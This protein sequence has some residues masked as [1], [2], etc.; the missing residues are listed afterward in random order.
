MKKYLLLPFFILLSLINLYGQ[1]NNS[2]G[3]YFTNKDKKFNDW[4]V[5][6]FGGYSILQNAD[7]TSW[8]G[9]GLQGL[10]P[11][12]DLNFLVN[13]QITHAFGLSA[14][15][16]YGNT[17]QKGTIDD[18][19]LSNYIGKAWG[20]TEYHAISIIGDVNLSN[21]LRRTDNRTNFVWELHAYAGAGF[22][23]YEAKRNN[24]NGSGNQF[25]T[26]T[27]QNIDDKSF[28]SQVGWG[29]RR[30]INKSVDVEFKNMYVLTGDETFDASGKPAPGHWTAAD[31]KASREDN[32][33]T[34]SLGVHY[35]FGKHDKALQWVD[36]LQNLSVTVVGNT[37]PLFECIDNDNDGVCDQW[38]KCLE[39]P[40]GVKV[41]G[42][43]CPLDSDG[44]GIPDSEDK[45][46]TIA[47]PISN[48]GCP[49]KLVRISGADV[50]MIVNKSIEGIE[51]DYNSDKIREISYA[52]LNAAAAVLLDN[53]DMRFY[54]EGHTDAAGNADYNLKLSERRA[55]SVIRYLVSKGVRQGNLIAVGMG[56]SDLKWPECNPVTNCPPWKNLENRRVI[57]KEI[58]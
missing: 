22:I 47:G 37:E 35:K 42:S 19:Y 40:A 17:R 9:P 51:F 4:S 41:D 18:Q 32:M 49:E 38:D 5:S 39:T 10:A 53:P 7:L 45:C 52:K 11:G 25:V 30:R 58:Q 33:M 50:A 28:Y 26:V 3:K 55:N 56:K 57:F 12:Y 43:G 27:K 2:K 24:F 46:P 21:L 8:Q 48:G 54:V 44:D 6:F 20:K 14:Q 31:T 16:S 34:F 13:K 29:I 15:F 36:P 1:Q 23:G